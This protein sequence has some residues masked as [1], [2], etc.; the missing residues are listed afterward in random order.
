[1]ASGRTP[2]QAYYIDVAAGFMDRLVLISAHELAP[3]VVVF[4]DVE[5]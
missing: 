4:Y 1:M 3:S 2:N 5:E